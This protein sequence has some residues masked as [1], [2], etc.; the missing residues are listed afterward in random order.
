MIQITKVKKHI[1]SKG[2]RMNRQAEAGINK[3]VEMLL[4]KM[5]ENVKNSKTKTLK[6]EH[7]VVNKVTKTVENVRTC[8]KCGN[9]PTVYINLARNLYREVCD[10][11]WVMAKKIKAGKVRGVSL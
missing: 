9:I 11:A 2:F 1:S 8:N 4:D 3:Q 6:I 10:K 7:T 5:L